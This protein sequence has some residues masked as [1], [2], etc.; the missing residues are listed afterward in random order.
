MYSIERRPIFFDAIFSVIGPKSGNRRVHIWMSNSPIVRNMNI[1]SFCVL[2][3]CGR[4]FRASIAEWYEQF[5]IF[6]R[7]YA[8][9]GRRRLAAANWMENFNF[10][11]QKKKKNSTICSFLLIFCSF[12][13]ETGKWQMTKVYMEVLTIWFSRKWQTVSTLLAES[14]MWSGSRRHLQ[15][16]AVLH[17]NFSNA[18]KRKWAKIFKHYTQESKQTKNKSVVECDTLNAPLAV[19]V[20]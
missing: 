17:F 2:W 14:K 6:P 15:S 12:L 19:L 9:I 10:S 3:R 4:H 5:F 8:T 18:T 16:C 13:H 11:K 7:W 1:L 20:R